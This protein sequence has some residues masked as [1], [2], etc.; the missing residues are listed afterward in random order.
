MADNP[1]LIYRKCPCGQQFR[2]NKI[3]KAITCSAACE[4]KYGH[5]PVDKSVEM[6]D[7]FVDQPTV[8]KKPS[9]PVSRT[10]RMEVGKSV[11]IIYPESIPAEILLRALQVGLVNSRWTLP[12]GLTYEITIEMISGDYHDQKIILGKQLVETV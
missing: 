6:V 9:E 11:E 12:D 5:L 4:K 10:R 2:I 3:S 7:K 1:N 8:A